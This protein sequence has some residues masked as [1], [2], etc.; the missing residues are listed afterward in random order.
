MIILVLFDEVDSKSRQK[1]GRQLVSHGYDTD[2]N[3]NIVMPPEPPGQIGYFHSGMG[4]WV[5]R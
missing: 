2:T 5:L 3:E 1:T 4:E